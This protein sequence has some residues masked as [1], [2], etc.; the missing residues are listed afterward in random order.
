MEANSKRPQAP[1]CSATN[2]AGQRCGSVAGPDGLCSIHGGRTDP[3]ELG[4]RGGLASVRS[5][6][7]LG[8]DVADDD[9]RE[10]ARARLNSM[11]DS[12]D[13]KTQLSAAKSLF[14]YGATPPSDGRPTGAPAAS[15]AHDHKAI[16]DNLERYGVIA[17]RP[18]SE[19]ASE[20]FVE[21]RAEVEALRERNKELEAELARRNDRA[22]ADPAR[23][24]PGGG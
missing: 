15:I 12:D 2:R 22:A 24:H 7:G 11:L 16:R 20:R 4:R 1:R 21:L 14:S 5:R 19:A 18:G 17:Y 6:L 9:L 13:E 10:K 3:V 23:G 8:P